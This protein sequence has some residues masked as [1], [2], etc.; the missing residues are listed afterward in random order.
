MPAKS[1]TAEKITRPPLSALQQ[2]NENERLA[3]LRN[4]QILDTP[5]EAVFDDLVRLAAYI[6]GTPVSLM[7]L[8][9]AERQW[10]KASVGDTRHIQSRREVA[11]C[12]YAMLS[13]DVFEVED[14]TLDPLFRQ[15]PMVVDDPNVRFYAGAALVTPEGMPLGTICAID[16]EPRRLTEQQRDALRVLAREAVAHLELRR[17]RHQLEQEQQKLEGL[18]RMA[19]DAAESMFVS[20]RN[21]I[22]VKQDHKLVRVYTGDIRYVE[23]LGDYVNIYTGR[24]RYTVYTTMKELEAKLSPRDFARVHRKYIIRLDGI[25]AI[26]GDVVLVDTGRSIDKQSNLLSVPIGNS[27]KA[28]LLSRLNLI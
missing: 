12:Q 23:A 26:E 20:N 25:A 27:Y 10:F 1:L 18:L 21:E 8:I 7:S 4:Y 6:C 16:T 19:N 9:D 24:E 2:P 11:F 14:A 28:A 15:N 5:P 17:A 13:D 3:A 22:F